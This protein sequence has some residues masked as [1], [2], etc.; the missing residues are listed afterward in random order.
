ML[1]ISYHNNK[2]VTSINP[3]PGDLET[4][5]SFGLS[6]QLTDRSREI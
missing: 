3:P 2:E 6:N 4:I 5:F 1:C